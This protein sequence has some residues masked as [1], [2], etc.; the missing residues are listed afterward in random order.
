MVGNSTEKGKPQISIRII[1]ETIGSSQGFR[2]IL[3]FFACMKYLRIPALL[4]LVPVMIGGLA[5]CS[6]NSTA[7]N[8]T[9]TTPGA[10]PAVG[11][12]FIMADN[13]SDINFDTVIAT[14][15]AQSDTA[16]PGSTSREISQTD[17]AIGGKTSLYES[18]LPN[19]DL[20]LEGFSTGWGAV[21]VYEV[22]PFASHT[23]VRNTFIQSN[24]GNTAFDTTIAVYNGAGS[25]IVLN[26]QTYQTDSVTV[27]AYIGGVNQ[28]VQ[29]FYTFIPAL[30]LIS[31]YSDGFYSEWLTSYSP[32]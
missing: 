6:K 8:T 1:V 25:P 19:G 9:T 28:T 17:S 29:Y 14:P 31:Y 4:F 16:H 27:T 5:S 22:L 26:H 30:G 11:S 18:F 7:P 15:A 10:I 32:K 2:F 21:G 23:T 3:L 20:A 13:T 24:G 12:T